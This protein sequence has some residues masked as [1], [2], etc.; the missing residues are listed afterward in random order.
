M[1]ITEGVGLVTAIVVAMTAFVAAIGTLAGKIRGA[2]TEIKA[3]RKGAQE[4]EKRTDDTKKQVEEHAERLA[5]QQKVINSLVAY[6]MSASI[7]RH[8][9][10]I[11]L[12]RT[13]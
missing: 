2:W 1:K 11:T 3:L 5:D 8:L 7:F 4:Q 9:C 10:G 13:Y 6:A 12:L